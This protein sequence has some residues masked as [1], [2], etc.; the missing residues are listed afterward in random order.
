MYKHNCQHVVHGLCAS[1]SAHINALVKLAKEECQKAPVVVIMNESLKNQ[2]LEK[3]VTAGKA[4]IIPLFGANVSDVEAS[5][6]ISNDFTKQNNAGVWN[7]YLIDEH[8]GTGTDF[9][10]HPDIEMNG[11]VRVIIAV[12]PASYTELC[13]FQRRT[14]RLNNKGKVFYVVDRSQTKFR[15][16]TRDYLT[17]ITELLKAKADL[18][19]KKALRDINNV[20]GETERF[21]DCDSVSDMA[22]DPQIVEEGHDKKEEKNSIIGGDC[23]DEEKKD[24]YFDRGMCANCYGETIQGVLHV[25]RLEKINSQK[26]E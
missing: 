5:K 13:Q 14:A 2:L 25:C 11:G 17:S 9:P 22:E 8:Q 7:C 26:Q 4:A 15:G 20:L 3:T 1:S 12:Q 6:M 18:D 23:L 21:S 24:L 19:V 16:A 10:S